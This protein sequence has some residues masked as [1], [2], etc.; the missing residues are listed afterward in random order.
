[1]RLQAHLEEQRQKYLQQQENTSLKIKYPYVTPGQISDLDAL[2]RQKAIEEG[3]E[4]LVV[5]KT[6]NEKTDQRDQQVDQ[7]A[8]MLKP[9]T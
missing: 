5:D 3:L 6:L 1:M 9:L 8:K 4:L 2:E 7:Q